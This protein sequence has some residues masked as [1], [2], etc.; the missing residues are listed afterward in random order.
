MERY[1][2][3]NRRVL[4]FRLLRRIVFGN[5]NVEC[6]L[7]LCVPASLREGIC[8]LVSIHSSPIPIHRRRHRTGPKKHPLFE[9]AYKRHRKFFIDANLA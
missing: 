8:L 3:S 6:C 4:Q 7:S 1:G 2:V 5:E 9:R